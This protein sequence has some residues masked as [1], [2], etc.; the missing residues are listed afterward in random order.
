MRLETFSASY[1]GRV[2]DQQRR[3][4]LEIIQCPELP[5]QW[6]RELRA[7]HKGR[8]SKHTSVR[9]KSRSQDLIKNP[10][11]PTY[12]ELRRAEAD[13]DAGGLRPR[14]AHPE[15]PPARGRLRGEGL[16]RAAVAGREHEEPRAGRRGSRNGG[17]EEEGGPHA[18][19]GHGHGALC[20]A[21]LLRP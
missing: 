6:L 9:L 16:A 2:A 17:G 18:V 5:R 8:A 15:P 21:R 14:H 19:N 7:H 12:L 13:G 3:V 1:T 4:A 10:R 20:S 11:W